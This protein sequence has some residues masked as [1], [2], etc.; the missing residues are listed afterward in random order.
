MPDARTPANDRLSEARARL[1]DVLE[2]RPEMNAYKFPASAGDMD[3]LGKKLDDIAASLKE[4][5]GLLARVVQNGG[6]R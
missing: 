4:I 1:A 3:A 6:G 5:S 2:E